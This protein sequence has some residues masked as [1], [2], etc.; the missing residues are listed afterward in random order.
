MTLSKSPLLNSIP[1][2][3]VILSM[4]MYKLMLVRYIIFGILWRSSLKLLSVFIFW[5]VAMLT[6][7]RDWLVKSSTEL[8]LDSLRA[9]GIDHRVICAYMIVIV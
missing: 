6:I 1:Q 9:F 8:C 7:I 5:Y 2:P 4:T 3:L